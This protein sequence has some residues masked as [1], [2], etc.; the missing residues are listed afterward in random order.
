[1]KKILTILIFLILVSTVAAEEIKVNK[2]A[3]ANITKGDILEINI[4]IE[5]NIE[6][7]KN[8]YIKET[9]PPG[10]ELVDEKTVKIE[11]HDGIKVKIYEWNLELKDIKTSIRYKIKPIKLGQY[12]LKPTSIKINNDLYR[13]NSLEFNVNCK[14]NNLCEEGE[15]SLNCPQDCKQGMKDGIC[16][17]KADNLCDPDCE[18][19]PDCVINN[20][21]NS[22]LGWIIITLL[23][24]I[25][26]IIFLKIKKK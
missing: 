16:D 23:I 21:Q 15:N 1:M 22:N 12:N 20:N 3:K 19:E 7:I 13:S 2:I 17:Y 11:S 5:K 18:D 14:A 24:I 10:I 6:G 26:L 9:L 8:A 4:E 25:G